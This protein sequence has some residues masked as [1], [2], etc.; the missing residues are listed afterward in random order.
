[1][2]IFKLFLKLVKV[3]VEI[4]FSIS[5]NVIWWIGVLPVVLWSQSF[6]SH[7]NFYKLLESIECAPMPILKP[8]DRLFFEDRSND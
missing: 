8:V 2:G 3:T 6:S 7:V 5:L 4:M 1:M